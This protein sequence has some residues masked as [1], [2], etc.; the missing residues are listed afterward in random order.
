MDDPITDIIL[1]RV[2][3][4]VKRITIP[5]YEAMENDPKYRAYESGGMLCV[6]TK[7]VVVPSI[8][9]APS[10]PVPIHKKY[11]DGRGRPKGLHY[12]Y[13]PKADGTSG[14]QTELI[15]LQDFADRMSKHVDDLD[16]ESQAFLWGLFW[17]GVRKSELYERIVE[18]VKLTDVDISIDFHQRKKHSA[19]TPPLKFP[20]TYPGIDVIVAW[21]QRIAPRAPV[22]KRVWDYSGGVTKVTNDKCKYL[23]PHVQTTKALYLVK[24]V[25]GEQYYPHFFRLNRLSTIGRDKDCSIVRMKSFSGL[26]T[27]AAIEFYLGTSAE[28]TDAAIAFSGKDASKVKM[29]VNPKLSQTTAIVPVTK[30]S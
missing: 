17:C 27:V 19:S 20:R 26:R 7:P 24:H 8:E 18:D 30:R 9:G 25:M 12:H 3:G 2:D 4:V 15:S 16:L 10:I 22:R 13:T 28:E 21:Y 14:K 6:D 23:F 1:V 5:E 11:I 29:P